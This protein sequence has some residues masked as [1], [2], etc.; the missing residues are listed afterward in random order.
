MRELLSSIELNHEMVLKCNIIRPETIHSLPE[1]IDKV[2]E[3]LN[4]LGTNHY[5]DNK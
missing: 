2:K 3:K 1:L 4:P 5:K